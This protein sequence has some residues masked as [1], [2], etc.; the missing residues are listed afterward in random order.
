[1]SK[2]S[3]L[4]KLHEKREELERQI[5]T[6]ILKS[7]LME[8]ASKNKNIFKNLK[9]TELEYYRYHYDVGGQV[10]NDFE[11]T[12]KLK[13]TDNELRYHY[14]NAN[15]DNFEAEQ[16]SIIWNNELLL[17]FDEGC[18]DYYDE[19]CEYDNNSESDSTESDLDSNASKETVHTTYSTVYKSNPCYKDLCD[20]C[21]FTEI[22]EKF[23]SMKK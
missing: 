22:I 11:F 10:G 19:C 13:N 12:I 9:C 8:T 20:S 15:N 5:V 16:Y 4:S 3:E 14:S 7:N 6:D 1:M 21:D 2:I 23:I 18:G 17:K